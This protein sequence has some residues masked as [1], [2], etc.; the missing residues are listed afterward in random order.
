MK[1]L[2]HRVVY[3][4]DLRQRRVSLTAVFRKVQSQ[5]EACMELVAC[6]KD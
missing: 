1:G 6:T 4:K 2:N 5:R 3:L